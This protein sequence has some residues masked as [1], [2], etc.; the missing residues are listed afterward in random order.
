MP[1]FLRL[2]PKAGS[3]SGAAA[4][5]LAPEIWRQLPAI[6]LGHSLYASFNWFFDHVLYVYVVYRFG[7]LQGGAIMTLLSFVQCAATLVF[8]EKMHIDW[9]GAG[10]LQK[11]QA[12]PSPGPLTRVL[13]RISQW[14]AP[15]IFVALCILQ[16]P[17]IATAVHRR[18]KFGQ[19]TRRDWS[20][21]SL[22]VLVANLYWT[23]VA[24]AIG[25]ALAT[26]WQF[27]FVK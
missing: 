17:F 9:V 19:L 10:L 18:G 25:I 2:S 4:E 13:N 26:V 5:P 1:V 15:A 23:F 21:F 22:A 20:V 3:A 27:L 7:L 8:Y 12:H 6:G 14:P 24:S 11:L 16:D